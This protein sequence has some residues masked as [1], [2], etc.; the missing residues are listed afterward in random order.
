MRT[1]RIFTAI[2]LILTGAVHVFASFI[3]PGDQYEIPV[4]IFGLVY[5]ATGIFLFS[6][7][8]YASLLGMIFP[9]LGLCVG[10]IYPGPAHWN[11]ALSIL[12]AVDII[13]IF[14]SRILFF[15]SGSRM[16]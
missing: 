6:G 5:L 3:I 16:S 15:R 2:L 14:C 9:A 11:L 8:K 10:I 4:L 1:L 12:L 7:R 13:A